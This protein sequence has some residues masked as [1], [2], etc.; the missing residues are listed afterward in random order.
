MDATYFDIITLEPGD[1]SHEIWL[2]RRKGS[3]NDYV[4]ERSRIGK[5]WYL[6]ERNDGWHLKLDDGYMLPVNLIRRMQI[7]I[8]VWK[9]TSPFARMNTRRG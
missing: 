6:G 7:A 4:E 9:R 2:V 8:W 3:K 1:M 5:V